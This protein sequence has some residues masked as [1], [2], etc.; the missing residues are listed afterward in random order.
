MVRCCP[1][2][3]LPVMRVEVHKPAEKNEANI[4]CHLDQTSLANK[5]FIV[6][7]SGTFYLRDTA[8]VEVGM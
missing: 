2:S 5:R 3:F 7:L 4:L 8:E 1:S 6:W